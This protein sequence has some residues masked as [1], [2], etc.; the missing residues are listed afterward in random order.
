M[1]VAVRPAPRITPG[2]AKKTILAVGVNKRVIVPPCGG[3][4]WGRGGGSGRRHSTLLRDVY[5]SSSDAEE[6]K[7]ADDSHSFHAHPAGAYHSDE[8]GQGK[9]G[10]TIYSRTLGNYC[11]SDADKE[12]R[13]QTKHE[14]GVTH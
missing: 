2:R 7:A 4:K 3:R 10:K 13:R 1:K 8:C 14:G 9:G 6:G 11:N 12:K 5:K